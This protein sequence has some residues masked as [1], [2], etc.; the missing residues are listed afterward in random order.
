MARTGRRGGDGEQAAGFDSLPGTPLVKTRIPG[1]KSRKA[2]AEQSVYESE[3]RIYTNYFPI[4]VDYGQNSSIVDLDGNIFLDWFAGV[5]VNILGHA[6]PII[7]DAIESQ[8]RRLVH[9]NDMPTELRIEFLKNLNQSLPKGLRNR[10]KVMFTVTGADAC[11]AAISLARYVTQRRTIVAFSGAFHGV[12][13]AIVG[14]T[15]NY[16]YAQYAGVPPYG[17]VHL[18]YPYTYRFPIVSEEDA[19]KVVVEMLEDLV[20][21]PASGAGPVAGVIVEPVQGE[22]GYV[23]PPKDFLPMLRE[24]TARHSIPLITDEVQSGL[25]RTGKM[26]ASD[27]FGVTPDIICVSKAIGGGI[28]MSLI[29]YDAEYD[30]NIPIGFHAGTYRGNPLAIAAGNAVLKHL[31]TTNLIEEVGAKGR[32]FRKRMAEIQRTQRKIGE[33]RG[34]GLMNGVELVKSPSTRSPATETASAIRRKLL[35]KGILMHTCGNYSNV[36]RSMPS[37]TV[38]KELMETGIEIFSDVMHSA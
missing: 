7:V 27:N 30:K 35:E 19:G 15:A 23:V 5:C 10:A 25:G 38:E 3:S 17:M 34:L 4:A 16:K 11:E 26:W 14:A 12:H 36:L 37:L 9:W 33:V 29:A 32:L 8:A 6:N 1:P 13:G 22:G 24:V 20:K 28:P 21:N 31:G 18:P 2:L